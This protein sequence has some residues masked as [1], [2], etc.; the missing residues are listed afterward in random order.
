MGSLMYEPFEVK[1]N[2]ALILQ[3]NERSTENVLP[4]NKLHGYSHPRKRKIFYRVSQTIR[5][6]LKLIFYSNTLKHI[7]NFSILTVYN[8]PMME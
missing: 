8:F 6:T 1:T 4:A 7:E 2:N 3:R 5:N